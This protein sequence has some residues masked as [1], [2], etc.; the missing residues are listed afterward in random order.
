MKNRTYRY[1]TGEALYPFG[2]GLSYTSFKYEDARL[3]GRV[4]GVTVTNEGGMA[5]W[6]VVQ[7]YIRGNESKYAAANHSLCAFD[8]VFLAPGQFRRVC[9]E[10]PEAALTV[11][12]EEG[13][14]LWTAAASR[15]L[16]AA[17]SRTSAARS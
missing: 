9:L 15:F 5:G 17:A 6:E 8:R 2:Y 12:D 11:V 4:L 16:S 1:F 13:D 14:A 7:A 3:E 10:I